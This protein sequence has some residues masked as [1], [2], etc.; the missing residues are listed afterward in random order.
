MTA[1]VERDPATEDR[2]RVVTD[3]RVVAAGLRPY[4]ALQI[5]EDLN[6][7]PYRDL[8]ARWGS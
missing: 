4:L 1:R 3:G 8:W 2:F 5:A 6:P 7:G